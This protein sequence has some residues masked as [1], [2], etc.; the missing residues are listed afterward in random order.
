MNLSTFK[1]SLG[2]VEELNILKN[3]NLSERDIEMLKDY[4]EMEDRFWEKYKHINKD[5]LIDQI[6]NII[7]LL[8]SSEEAK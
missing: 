3:K 4:N 2:H 1:Q 6:K 7:N 5:I 8:K